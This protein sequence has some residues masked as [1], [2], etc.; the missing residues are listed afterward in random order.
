MSDPAAPVPAEGR[1][2]P[3]GSAFWG[4]AAQR[5]G[6]IVP[7]ARVSDSSFG[8]GAPVIRWFPEGRLNAAVTCIDRHLPDRADQA[9]L[10]W[11]SRL[12]DE[13]ARR[14]SYALLH[15]ETCAMANVLRQLG[16]RRGDRVALYLP[17]MPETVFAMLACAR[18]G[19]IHVVV[20]AGLAPDA[21]AHRLRDCGA[22]LL[23][24]ADHAPWGEGRL[25][26]LKSLA[27]A[28]LAQMPGPCACLL[29]KRTGGQTTW[30]AG[31]DHDHEE[32]RQDVPP[33][34]PPE[35]MAAEDP[36]FLLHTSG[37]TGQPRAVV[38][39]T[40]G[41]LVHVATTH[42]LC[43]EHAEGDVIWC[44]GDLGWIAGH[45]Y[46]LYGPLANGGTVLM[47]EGAPDFTDPGRPWALCAA[48][49]VTQLYTTPTAL[50]SFRTAGEDW[51]LPHDLSA[52]RILGAVGEPLAPDI[53]AWSHQTV[54]RGQARVVDTWWQT[55]S[56]GHLI[57]PRRDAGPESDAGPRPL[58]GVVP[59]ILDLETLDEL[60]TAPAE[61]LLCLRQS[62]PGQSPGLWGDLVAPPPEWFLPGRGLY[63]T[64]DACLR[65]ADGSYRITGR[66]DDVITVS[67]KR[68]GAA[69]V[70]RAL[71]T[72]RRVAQAAVVGFAHPEKGMGI[73][74]F[75]RLHGALPSDEL[76]QA[77]CAH[78]CEVIGE[79]ARPDRIAW[80][81]TLP[82][83][84]SGKI[85]RRLLRQ[86]AAG[87]LPEQ[88]GVLANPESLPPL[89]ATPPVQT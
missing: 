55:E 32:L 10:I 48:H 15:R 3:E 64:G 77:L 31:R 66:V 65:A 87:T 68:V 51:L 43:F 34:C 38:H 75:V 85:L 67:G 49:R 25:R 29:I 63:V 6:W 46:G 17:M 83:T 58:P 27:D 12:P 20:H 2:L 56:G 28:A 70:E 54:G 74:A 1:P 41:Y 33:D 42:A 59:V 82:Q 81:E 18:I 60:D 30:I 16:V 35:P 76:A 72:H 50:R 13:P 37:S 79:I 69:E 21:L 5:I 4:E 24:T 22:R 26:P 36:L 14:I 9:A 73:Q 44:T 39:A 40:G 53:A 45:S 8:P 84:R 23:V 61:G 57:A 52:L 80:A 86:I 7:P 78:V 11:E 89:I 88:T 71:C 19:A 47:V 62:W